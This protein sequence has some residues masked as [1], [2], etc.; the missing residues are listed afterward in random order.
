M[1][2]V[3]ILQ[4][5]CHFNIHVGRPFQ[6]IT[7]SL[8]N[9]AGK[10]VHTGDNYNDKSSASDVNETKIRNKNDLSVGKF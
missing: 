7:F 3:A 4:G 10:Y 2:Q 8:K 1:F 9:L 5:P 6:V